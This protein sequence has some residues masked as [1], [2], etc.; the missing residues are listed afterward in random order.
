MF[1]IESLGFHSFMVDTITAIKFITE[2]GGVG[3]LAGVVLVIYF[4]MTIIKSG[5]DDKSPNPLKELL[6]G[7]LMVM[8]FVGPAA[9]TTDVKIRSAYDISSFE[10]VEDV[11]LLVVFPYWIANQGLAELSDLVTTAFSPVQAASLK[12]ADP[13]QAILKLYNQQ[14]SASLNYGGPSSSQGFDLQKTMSNY[15]DDCVVNDYL[16]DGQ[17]PTANM[18]VLRRTPM[19][20]DLLDELRVDY[21][22]ISTV[23]DQYRPL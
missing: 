15:I 6:I 9:P 16:L 2:L 10:I 23:S 8:M 13:L 17:D 18:D 20:R 12:E 21:N 19:S 4:G 11:P 14:P 1:E 3:G 7:G 22:G 5:L